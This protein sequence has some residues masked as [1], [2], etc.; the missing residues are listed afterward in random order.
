M[1]HEA[2][3]VMKTGMDA[4]WAISSNELAFVNSMKM[5]IAVILGV[6]HM[7]TGIILKGLNE[8]YFGR[9]LEFL[10]EFLPQIVILLA[11]FGYMDILIVV[12]WLTD[13]TGREDRAPSII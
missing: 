10:F 6:V 4:T 2:N 1:T 7:S 5:K 9:K 8:I 11:L 13:F 3:C 12:K